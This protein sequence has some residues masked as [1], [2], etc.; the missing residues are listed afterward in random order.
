MNVMMMMMMIMM[1]MMVVMMMMM[2]VLISPGI[3]TKIDNF[4]ML[5]CLL[6]SVICNCDNNCVILDML[7]S[8]RFKLLE[9]QR[10]E[11]RDMMAVGKVDTHE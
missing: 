6:I 8:L 5:T 2:I 3:Y 4:E 11:N 1:T 7:F 9:R 10:Q